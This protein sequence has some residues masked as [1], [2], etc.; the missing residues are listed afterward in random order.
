MLKRLEAAAA[1][2]ADLAASLPRL[3]AELL[4]AEGDGVGAEAALREEYETH[5]E[6]LALASALARSLLLQKRDDD[7]EAVMVAHAEAQED[8]L[9]SWLALAA[10]YRTWPGGPRLADASAALTRAL[11]TSPNDPRALREMMEVRLAQGNAADALVLCDRYLEAQPDSAAVLHIKA[12]LITR[13]KG[14]IDEALRAVDTAIALDDRIEFRVTRG[15]FYCD[16]GEYEKAMEDLEEVRAQVSDTSARVDAALAEIYHETG[17][18]RLAQQYYEAARSKSE[19]G[20]PVD[21]TRM[22]KLKQ[23]LAENGE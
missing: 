10:I 7:A 18:T 22:I 13:L 15:L 5:P 8:D 1:T 2:D 19:R 11:L 12:I 23:A 9:A 21:R 3:R 6:E 16:K 4:L 20:Q 14:S 17:E